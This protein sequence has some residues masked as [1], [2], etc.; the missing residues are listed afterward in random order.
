MLIIEIDEAI[1]QAIVNP[2]IKLD[3]NEKTQYKNEWRTYR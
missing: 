1:Y 2:D 3:K